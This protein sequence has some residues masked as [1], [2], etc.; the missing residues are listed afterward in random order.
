MRER[1]ETEARVGNSY[2]LRFISHDIGSD[3]DQQSLLRVHHLTGTVSSMYQDE[4]M[5][6]L[7]SVAFFQ[8]SLTFSIVPTMEFETCPCQVWG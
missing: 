3:I 8:C 4:P 7:R 2:A 1:G 6:P 5:N